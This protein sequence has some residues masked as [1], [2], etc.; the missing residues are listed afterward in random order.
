MLYLPVAKSDLKNIFSRTVSKLTQMCTHDQG[1]GCRR[2][3]VLWI[4]TRDV[5]YRELE[6][7]EC[8]DRS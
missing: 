5:L 6:T 4:N 2:H 3:H 7:K 8:V 1:T